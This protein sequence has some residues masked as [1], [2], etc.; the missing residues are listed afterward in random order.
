[1]DCDYFHIYEYVF[2]KKVYITEINTRKL[3][4]IKEQHMV[5]YLNIFIIN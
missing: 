2:S 1:M 3:I 4:I 5:E